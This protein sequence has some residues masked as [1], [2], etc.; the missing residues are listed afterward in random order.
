MDD[1]AFAAIML[2]QQ[3]AIARCLDNPEHCERRCREVDGD[4]SLGML[5]PLGGRRAGTTC[6]LRP[7]RAR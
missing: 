1:Q 2:A 3:T 7:R 4:R 6:G 5:A